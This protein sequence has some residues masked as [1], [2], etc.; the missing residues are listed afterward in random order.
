MAQGQ[1][2]IVSFLKK[3]MPVDT[4]GAKAGPKGQPVVLNVVV[5][6]SK[7]WG[8]PQRFDHLQAMVR[9]QKVCL[10]YIQY[11]LNMGYKKWSEIFQ[12][13]IFLIFG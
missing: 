6:Y 10:N 8:S 3:K 11:T 5:I 13:W 7:G 9:S 1:V 12:Y 2:E 4:Q